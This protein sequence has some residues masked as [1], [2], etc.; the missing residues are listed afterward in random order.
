M[1]EMYIYH[2][3]QDLF[4]NHDQPVLNWPFNVLNKEGESNGVNVKLGYFCNYLS[5]LKILNIYVILLWR[6]NSD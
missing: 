5:L 4:Y 1:G 2:I 6:E 3:V